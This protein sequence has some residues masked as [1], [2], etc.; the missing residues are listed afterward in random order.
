[1]MTTTTKKPTQK[2]LVLNHLRNG[3]SIDAMSAQ[4]LCRCVRLAAV[5]HVLKKE[6]YDIVKKMVTQNDGVRL[7]T[8]RMAS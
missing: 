1:M 5:I 4:R 7:A 2:H 6:G 8:Y 3:G